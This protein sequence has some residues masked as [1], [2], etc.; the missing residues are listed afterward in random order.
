M[1]AWVEASTRDL[2]PSAA[3]ISQSKTSLSASL[4][5]GDAC[6]PAL[7][8]KPSLMPKPFAFQRNATIRPIKAPKINSARQLQ[9]AASSDA[10]DSL[11]S[12]K[13]ELVETRVQNT[14]ESVK[15]NGTLKVSVKSASTKPAP[16]GPKPALTPKTDLDRNPNTTQMAPNTKPED[17]KNFQSRARAKSLGSQEQKALRQTPKGESR[18]GD[19]DFRASSLCWPVRNRLSVGLTSRFESQE[20]EVGSVRR[21]EPPLSPSESKPQEDEETSGTSIKR[22]ISLLFDRSAA[23]QHRDV[24]N[25]KDSAPAEISV[26]IKQR[27]KNLSLNTQEPRVRLPSTGDLKCL[28]H[29]KTQSDS[30]QLSPL[31]HG[32]AKTTASENNISR[33]NSTLSTAD[34]DEE[35]EE[36]DDDATDEDKENCVSVPVYRRVGMAGMAKDP[37]RKTQEE[38]KEKQHKEEQLQKEW[39]REKH[40][41]EERKLR[42]EMERRQE[43]ECLKEERKQ[44]E[45]KQRQ[46]EERRKQELERQKRIEEE[47]KLQEEREREAERE[48]R[49]E[50]E[51]LERD[52]QIEE[53]KR[54]MEEKREKERQREEQ[55]LREE[56]EKERL[57]KEKEMEEERHRI[58]EERQR[59]KLRLRQ[60]REKQEMIKK[61]RE[62]EEKKRIEEKERL[63]REKENQERLKKE[64][65]MEEKRLLE[66]QRLR[67]EREKE[68]RLKKEREMEEKRL[69][70]EQRLRQEREKEERLKKER[71]MEEKRLLEEQRLRQEREKEER[72]KKEREVEERKQL[73]EQ[74]LRL[75]REEEERLKKEREIEEKKRIEEEERLRQ[76]R[77]M[78]R[79]RKKRE[80]EERRQLEEQRLR[81]EREKEERFKKEREMEEKRLLEVQRLRLERLKEERLKKEREME[82]RKQMEEEEKL[83][84]EREMERIRKEREMEERRRLE[85]Q[86]L[87]QEREIKERLKKER[88]ME[89][90]RLLEEQRLRQESEK[91]RQRKEKEMEEKRQIEEEQ[92]LRQQREMERLRKERE[93]EE[94]R[95]REE[96]EEKLKQEREMEERRRVEDEKRWRQEREKARLRM[97]R[98]D[99]A[100]RC[101]LISFDGDE[102]QI[103]VSSQLP[104]VLYDDFS[105]KPRRWGTGTSRSSTP[106]PSREA[107]SDDAVHD[108]MESNDPESPGLQIPQNSTGEDQDP[109]YQDQTETDSQTSRSP[110]DHVTSQQGELKNCA[111]DDEDD[112]DE[113]VD[114]RDTETR[115]P[116]ESNNTDVDG[117][118]DN[119]INQLLQRLT[120]QEKQRKPS[121]ES[122]APEITDPEPLLFPKSSAP[123][124]DSSVFRSKADL[125]KKR[126][127]KR[128]RPSRAVRQRAALPALIEGSNLDWRFCDSSDGSK[129][130]NSESGEE[131][132]KYATPPP[133]PSRPKRVSLFPGMDQ[134]ALMAQLKRRSGLMETDAS[135]GQTTPVVSA[136]SPRTPTL[137]PRVLP[138]VNSRDTGSGSSPSWLRE[139][140]SKKRLSRPESDA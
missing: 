42:E 56:R 58:E 120:S 50:Q 12:S 73:E 137:G 52:K 138:P 113:Y 140:K 44:E 94:K 78:E 11:V 7:A 10:L 45:E 110:P 106:S 68:E 123:L 65:E 127:I 116:H 60:E 18:S 5:S 47:R 26:D 76:E 37:E 39:E 97:E 53:Q 133:A 29:E 15:P 89:E 25:K 32:P 54:R 125:G 91:E 69:L 83:R 122:D 75:E 71:E 99:V 70:E 118:A 13:S 102:T 130:Q 92:R 86:R 80:M 36:E 107:P 129:A 67:Q 131:P 23:S 82:E 95:L 124:L 98:D 139:L 22:R 74:R 105:V 6:K 27:I 41:E 55:R 121:I 136:R 77:E 119:K 111:D 46:R 4:L 87:R 101:D 90:K 3:L 40:L 43:E 19:A 132:S 17:D 112:E 59:E 64:R 48:T 34:D 81:Q 51:R 16:L 109:C 128:S 9:R 1:A 103:E 61:E 49:R 84:L 104:G 14:S 57:R 93:M 20:R 79:I 72:L 30:A 88:E 35:E 108:W 24:F 96:R 126:S 63:R 100:V 28:P 38:E 2:S 21:D 33:K 66:E 62:N 85:E 31:Q 135:E 114:E 8:P 134:S 117:F 115:I